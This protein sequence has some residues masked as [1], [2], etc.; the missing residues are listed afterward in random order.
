MTPELNK[1]KGIQ[2]ISVIRSVVISIT[3]IIVVILS[4]GTTLHTERNPEAN[5]KGGLQEIVDTVNVNLEYLRTLPDIVVYR[6]NGDEDGDNEHFLVFEA[7]LSDELLAVWTQSSV[8]GFG[9]NRIVFSRSADGNNWNIPITL[10]GKVKGGSDKQASWAFPVVSS[11]GRI[12]CFYTKE[13]DFPDMRQHSGSIGCVYSDDNGHTWTKETELRFKKNKFDN[14]DPKVSPNWIVWQKPIRDSNGKYLAGYTQ[15]SS[16]EVVKKASS[17]WTDHDSRSAFIRFENID[18]NPLPEEIH[19]T[20][21][22]DHG[23]GIEI[24]HKLFP[25]ISVSQEPA[26]VLLPDNRLFTVMRTMTGYIWYSVSD[27]NGRSWREPEILRYQDNGEP[28]KNPLV[29][30]PIYSI[31]EDRYLL[32]FYNNDGKMNDYD[33]FKEKWDNGNQLNFLRNPAH[34]SM[35]TFNSNAH[36]RYGSVNQ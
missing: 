24:P 31:S 16:T 9:D 28:I 36:Q 14:P 15:W 23:E 12:Y 1:T 34:L 21:L 20:W 22:P 27:D 30:C 33:Q 2:G 10:A 4:Y 8:E 19:L 13:T 32:I 35:G 6:P 17:K 26:V 5:Q 3:Y 25:E 7:P 11:K 18:D 29:S